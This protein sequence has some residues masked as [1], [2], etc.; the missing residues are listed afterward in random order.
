MHKVS[1]QLVVLTPGVHQFTPLLKMAA[2]QAFVPASLPHTFKKTNSRDL[3]TRAYRGLQLSLIISNGGK[4]EEDRQQGERNR[5]RRSVVNDVAQCFMRGKHC[6]RA[7][8]GKQ[9]GASRDRD[10]QRVR[11]R[12]RGGTCRGRVTPRTL[13]GQTSPAGCRT[14]NTHILYTLT[15]ISALVVMGFPAYKLIISGA[16]YE[17]VV[18]L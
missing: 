6:W 16:R 10:R 1:H 11:G 17:R 13:P 7:G 4:I 18:Y 14:H 3:F 5:T 9:P 8:R 2:V 12:E 15:Q